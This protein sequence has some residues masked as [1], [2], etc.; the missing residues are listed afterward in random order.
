MYVRAVVCFLF[1]AIKNVWSVNFAIFTLYHLDF[2]RFFSARL[3]ALKSPLAQCEARV[4]VR[5]FLQ[6]QT[7]RGR[8]FPEAAEQPYC[9][10]FFYYLA[11]LS[12]CSVY[13]LAIKRNLKLGRCEHIGVSPMTLTIFTIECIV[14][15]F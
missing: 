11:V 9:F 7:P 12:S 13:V 14:F 3:M 5:C 1:L 15:K 10:V 6:A 2:V 4:K 8:G